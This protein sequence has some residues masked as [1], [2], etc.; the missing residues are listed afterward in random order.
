MLGI[1]G[2]IVAALTHASGTAFTVYSKPEVAG[3]AILMARRAGA[4]AIGV[5]TGIVTRADFERRP[6]EERVHAVVESLTELPDLDWLE[7]SPR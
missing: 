5:T 6:E 3:L 2:A 7:G 1:S 4:H